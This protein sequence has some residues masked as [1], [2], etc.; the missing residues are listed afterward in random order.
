M[1]VMSEA[2]PNPDPKLELQ[3]DVQRLL[4]RCMLRVQQYEKILKAL[5]ALHELAGPVDTLE[6][7]RASRAEKLADKT[8]G[9]LVK[10]LFE[11]FVVPDEFERE[12]LPD[13]KVPTDRI[14]MAFSY[15][16]SMTPERWSKTKA[17]IEEMVAIRNDIVHHLID[18]FDLWSEEGC[19]SAI[20]HLEQSCDRIDRHYAE[21]VQW[22]KSTDESRGL[23][24]QFVRS[25]AFQDLLISGIGP[26]G[27]FEW[28]HT[29]IVRVLRE[30][31][32]VLSVNGWTR[33][34]DARTWIAEK[35]P[36]Q[37]PERYGRRSWP[38]VLTESRTFDLQYRA[39]EAGHKVAWFRFRPVAATKSRW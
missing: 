38:Q 28:P 26:D 20:D 18:Q 31:S 25:P 9:T 24:A 15:R 23:A 1:P 35:H 21:L 19:A 3:R 16:L 12:L 10:A 36:E 39:G 29:G 34:D 17:A 6:A 13:D 7:Q 32:L 11:S 22:A 27:S 37:T 30:A 14:S 4:G 8:L 2:P 33:L 5:V